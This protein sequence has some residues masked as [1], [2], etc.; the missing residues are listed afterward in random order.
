MR[1]NRFEISFSSFEKTWEQKIELERRF[2]HDGQ[3]AADLE[4]DLKTKISP[5]IRIKFNFG[6]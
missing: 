1:L 2:G 6:L 4:T 3:L 5:S